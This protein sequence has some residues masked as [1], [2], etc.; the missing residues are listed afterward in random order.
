MEEKDN[1]IKRIWFEHYEMECAHLKLAC[2]L[3]EKYEKGKCSTVIGT[4]EFPKLLTLG[5]NKQY[6]R[7]VL[8]RTILLTGDRAS[9]IDVMKLKDNADFFLYQNEIIENSA[10]VP[11][12]VVINKAMEKLGQDYRFQDTQNPVKE[13]QNRKKDNVT[14]GRSNKSTQ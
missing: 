2:H 9:Y 11:S 3:F 5:T 6:V 14:I 12:H 4:G 10:T 1:N 8:E 7:D 13:L